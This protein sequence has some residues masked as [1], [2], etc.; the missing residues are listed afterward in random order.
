MMGRKGV[1]IRKF[2]DRLMLYFGLALQIPVWISLALFYYFSIYKKMDLYV[3]IAVVAGA[4]LIYELI[5]VLLWKRMRMNGS[6]LTS[7]K[8][9]DYLGKMIMN[10]RMYVSEKV[11][12][13]NGKTRDK[14]IYFPKI[15]YKRRNGYITVRFPTDLQANQ[16]RFLKIGANLEHAFFADMVEMVNEQDYIRYKLLY[17]PEKARLSVDDIQIKDGKIPLMKEYS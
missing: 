11:T 16:D 8:H 5:F 9:M 7:F 4:L 3:G 15:Y 6:F 10:N 13:P 1:R 2:Y 14:M 17:A 12:I